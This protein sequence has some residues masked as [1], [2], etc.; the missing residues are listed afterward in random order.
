M[1]G[2]VCAVFD[3]NSS[4]G[5]VQLFCW[6]QTYAG[7][8]REPKLGTWML[9]GCGGMCTTGMTAASAHEHFLPVFKAV[10]DTIV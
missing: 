8:R 1:H 9:V 5:S 10:S 4:V 3:K 7:Q 6:S 2:W